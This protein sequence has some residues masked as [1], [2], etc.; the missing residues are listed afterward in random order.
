MKKDK[1]VLNL[2]MHLTDVD[3]YISFPVEE[4]GGGGYC[5]TRKFKECLRLTIFFYYFLYYITIIIQQNKN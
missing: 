3:C 1:Q 5:V 4:E 2:P